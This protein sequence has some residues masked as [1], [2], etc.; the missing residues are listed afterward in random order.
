MGTFIAD[1][2]LQ[3]LSFVAQSERENIKNDKPKELLPQKQKVLNLVDLNCR[4]PK[5]LIKLLKIGIKE[6]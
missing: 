4:C 1:L 2:V 3:I 5:T 6:R